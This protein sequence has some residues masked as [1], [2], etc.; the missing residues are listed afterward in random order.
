MLKSPANCTILK[1]EFSLVISIKISLLI[2]DF[3]PWLL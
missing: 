2:L 3:T 1:L